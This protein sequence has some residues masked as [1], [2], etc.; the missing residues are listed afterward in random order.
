MPITVS[1]KALGARRPLFADWSIPLPP[2]D[3][4]A[5]ATLTLRELI[6]I[7]VTAEVDSYESRRESRRLDRVLS[8]GQID[9][10][11]AAGKISPEGNETPEAPPVDIAIANALTAFEDGLYL[12]LVDEQEYRSLD[13]PVRL[14]PNSRVVFLRLTFLAGA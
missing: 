8:R 14:T 5:G 2:D 1:G 11:T 12:V 3:F 7:I 10:G 4:G 6:E 9:A 13:E